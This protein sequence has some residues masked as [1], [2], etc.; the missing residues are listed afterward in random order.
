MLMALDLDGVWANIIFLR[1][2]PSFGK[3]RKERRVV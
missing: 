3:S 1:P 2:G